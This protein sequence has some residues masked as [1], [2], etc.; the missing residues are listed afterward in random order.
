MAKAT[1]LA[2]EY[3][4]IFRKD[5]FL[6]LICF[7]R[8]GHNEL[9]DPSFTQ[10]LMYDVIN[11]KQSVPDAYANLLEARDTYNIEKK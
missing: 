5:I 8:W 3:R 7:R 6:D 9:D 2:L 11:S 10:P 4:E 1:R